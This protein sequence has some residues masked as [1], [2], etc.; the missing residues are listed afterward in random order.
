MQAMSYPGRVCV[1]LKSY[2]RSQKLDSRTLLHR[3]NF[4]SL[5]SSIQTRF[6]RFELLHSTALGCFQGTDHLAHETGKSDRIGLGR[7]N[8]R[9]R[10]V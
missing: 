3:G 5:D 10:A 7:R 6:S 1:R 2:L 8:K 9:D 4:L